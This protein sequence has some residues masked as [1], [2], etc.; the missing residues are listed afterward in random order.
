MKRDRKRTISFLEVV[1]N[2]IKDMCI[3][4]QNT[5]HSSG[6]QLFHTSFTGWLQLTSMLKILH[7]NCNI[8]RKC[9]NPLSLYHHVVDMLKI[10]SHIVAYS[11]AGIM[12]T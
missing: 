4:T 8:V 10:Y 7:F 2:Y 6:K 11:H 3:N 1:S 9:T 5:M 12:D